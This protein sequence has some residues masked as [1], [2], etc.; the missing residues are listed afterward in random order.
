MYLGVMREET[1][2]IFDRLHVVGDSLRLR[3]GD[4]FERTLDL[5]QASC[6]IQGAAVIPNEKAIEEIRDINEH[7]ARER[8]KKDNP[9][10]CPDCHSVLAIEN[11]IDSPHGVKLALVQH[12]A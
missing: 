11:D 7:R 1:T 6:T 4:D 3:I 5:L 9:L 10:R 8:A 12:A 2:A